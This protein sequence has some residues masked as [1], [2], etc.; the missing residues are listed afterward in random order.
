MKT[1]TLG[2]FVFCIAAAICCAL[3]AFAE[4]KKF[5]WSTANLK[6]EKDG[7]VYK[8]GETAAFKLKVVSA[9][10]T[11]VG[12]V[13]VE[14]K[15]SKDGFDPVKKFDAITDKNG[16]CIVKS[17]LDEAGFLRC[18]MKISDGKNTA[19]LT[20]GAAFEPLKIKAG[21]QIPGDF[22]SYWRMQKEILAKIPMNAQMRDISDPNKPIECFDITL[23]SFES[24]VRGYY[25]RPRGA[26]PKSCPA[27]ILPH[28][29]GV[30]TSFLGNAYRQAQKGFI[31]LDFNAHGIENG[32]ED[33]YY[34]SLS[35]G[36]LKN[37]PGRGIESRDSFYFRGM[38]MR[39]MRAMEFLQS[40]PEWDGKIFVVYGTSQGGGQ[41]I[42]ASAL[43][44]RVSFTVACVPA[45]C[46]LAGAA[47]G[48]ASGWP[49]FFSAGAD[50]EKAKSMAKKTLYY[51]DA[52]NFA[53]FVRN[54]V[55]FVVGYA[56]TTCAPTTVYSAYSNIKAPK[57]MIVCEE[58]GHSV[59][60]A[61]YR[62]ADSLIAEH[63]AKMRSK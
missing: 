6:A 39:L 8:I 23:D 28:A 14:V 52:T 20:A 42:V 27:I 35:A 43:N 57:H 30:C 11:G 54:P 45:M 13:K 16:V 60:W 25:C 56:D 58:A 7:S 32:K 48:R 38:Y 41:S 40:R 24:K 44:R 17:R 19:S 59:P 51:F 36:A 50:R 53:S 61:A 4:T 29:A 21:A 49:K 34:K 46:D 10:G 37:Y 55:V 62:Q 15:L 3:S 1:Y 33:S 47:M 63:V 18:E 26:K 31:A 12:G 22:K 2:R 5:G 9:L